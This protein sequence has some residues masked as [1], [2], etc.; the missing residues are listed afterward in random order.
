MSTH[1]WRH[2]GTG[3]ISVGVEKLSGIFSTV[4]SRDLPV[5]WCPAQ[6]Q[7][8]HHSSERR[9][10]YNLWIR[11]GHGTCRA[12]YLPSCASGAGRCSSH[13]CLCQT[14]AASRAWLAWL[15]RPPACQGTAAA[16]SGHGPSALRGS[17]HRCQA[18]SARRRRGLGHMNPSATVASGRAHTLSGVE[19]RGFNPSGEVRGALAPHPGRASGLN[20]WLLV[21]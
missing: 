9:Q 20:K 13:C 8:S 19:G 6:R 12:K 1:H 10:P 21:N 15:G 11:R 18:T 3:L 5:S 17:R 2:W 16:G 7:V 4:I 14:G